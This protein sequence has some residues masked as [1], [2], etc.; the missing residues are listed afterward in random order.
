MG[1]K[2]Y[3][4]SPLCT[5]YS[6]FHPISIS[7]FPTLPPLSFCLLSLPSPFLLCMLRLIVW[8]RNALMAFSQRAQISAALEENGAWWRWWRW[9]WGVG[10][11]QKLLSHAA[12]MHPSPSPSP[13]FSIQPSSTLSF[14]HATVVTAVVVGCEDRGWGG[15]GNR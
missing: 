3:I 12:I 9:W 6:T 15:G 14:L 8:T 5:T 11:F 1:K 2:S 4:F 7:P 13:S 10:I